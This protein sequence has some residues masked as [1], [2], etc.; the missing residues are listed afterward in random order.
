MIEKE[1]AS[2]AQRETAKKSIGKSFRINEN[3]LEVDRV[4]GM[5]EYERK[6][7]SEF[8]SLRSKMEIEISRLESENKVLTLKIENTAQEHIEKI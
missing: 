5:V 7:L 4:L 3:N 8:E 1:A 2:R 6:K